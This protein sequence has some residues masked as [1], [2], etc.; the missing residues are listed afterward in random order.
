MYLVSP[1]DILSANKNLKYFGGKTFARFILWMLRL[2]RCNRE[3]AKYYILESPDFLNKIIESFGLKYIVSEEDLKK[4]PETGPFITVSN[5]PTG[6]PEGIAL[7][8]MMT[9]KRAD[10]KFMVNFLLSRI[11]P[12]E[13][14]FI[15]VNPFETHKDA[16]SSL[17]GIK[18]AL[19]HVKEGNSLG[20]FPAG[21]VSAFQKGKKEITDREWLTVVLKMIKKAQV[22]ILPIYIEGKNSWWFYFL[23]RINPVLRTAKLPSEL[24]NKK[25]QVMRFR[26]GTPISVN[27]QNLF[28]DI[29]EFGNFLRMKT[30]S[31]GADM[32]NKTKSSGV[33]KVRSIAE[34]ISAD[35]IA[36][37]VESL[38]DEHQLFKVEN[39]QVFHASAA[40]IPSVMHEI[41][42]LR[43]HTYREVGE[44]TF[45]KL[46]LDSYDQYFHH[47]FI[48]DNDARKIVGAYR[49]G[50]GKEIMQTRG[51]KGFYIASLFK[52]NE[53]FYPVLEKSI[54]LG[55]SFICKEYQRK[56]LSLFLLWKGILYFLIKNPEYRYLIGPVSI[57]DA[58]SD[59]SKGLVLEFLNASYSHS[60]YASQLVPRSP[61]KYSI[62][63]Y[64]DTKVFRKYIG[65]DINRIDKFIHDV[66]PDQHI[67]VLLKKYIKQNAKILGAN[68]DAKFNFCVDVL[69]LLDLN[70]VPPEVIDSL[71]KDSPEIVL[72]V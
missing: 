42:R 58:C 35:I 17:A 26:I 46:D 37:E 67:P 44:G 32:L 45:K 36:R 22:P 24:L 65:S 16:Q 51:I 30:Y 72:P 69:M 47:L 20:I 2:D 43:E 56:A 29:T 27:D 6:G 62:S 25:R 71:S 48:W 59:F 54:E 34:P 4:I 1:D 12:L 13:P 28:D 10:Y 23:G 14:Y 9:Q 68:V 3:Y 66:E 38:G 64:I 49:M 41:G 70:D 33:K 19:N 63:D 7:I 52:I 60:E 57:S 39:Y 31:L 5:H 53:K 40:R 8:K 55:R 18:N 50:K 21:E 11:K 15:P 61:F